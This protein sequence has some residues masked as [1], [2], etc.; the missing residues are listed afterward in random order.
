MCYA[1]QLLRGPVPL[2]VISGDIEYA[3]MK[4]SVV[5]LLLSLL[6]ANAFAGGVYQEP[7]AF[8]AEAFADD[9]PKAEVIWP[10][11]GLK[12][13]IKDILG[14]DYKGLRIR[15]WKQDKRTAWIL[16]EIGKDKPITTG[17]VINNGRMERVR[18][19][20]FRESRGWEVRHAFFTDQ[21]DNASLHK[22]T[23]LDRHIDNIS[24]ATLS[25]RA[26]TKLARVALLLDKAV[27][28]QQ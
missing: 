19:L 2:F 27:N 15:Y 18:V 1:L 21:F 25:V 24:G 17:F 7:D 20:V 13:Q 5:I 28:V 22:D 14:H 9:P 8:I 12:A 6:S 11:T 16:D 23:Q 3:A 26:V 4:I 10:D